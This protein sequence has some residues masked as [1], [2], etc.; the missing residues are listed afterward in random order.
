MSSM[1][2]ED[3]TGKGCPL[4]GD[5]DVEEE[6]GPIFTHAFQDHVGGSRKAQSARFR[7]SNVVQFGSDPFSLFEKTSLEHLT[8]KED[9]G[10]CYT[11]RTPCM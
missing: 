9:C 6:P 2:V 4:K 8:H 5:K 1:V 3:G 7:G 10:G 11:G